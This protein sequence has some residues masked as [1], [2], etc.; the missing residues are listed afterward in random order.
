MA[1]VK[2]Q[3]RNMCRVSARYTSGK[4]TYPGSPILAS[5]WVPTTKIEREAS[6]KEVSDALLHTIEGIHGVSRDEL[7]IEVTYS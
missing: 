2:N 5:V 3:Q 4:P 7:T 1:T 6:L